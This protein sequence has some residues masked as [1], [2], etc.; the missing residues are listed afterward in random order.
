MSRN[1]DINDTL[2]TQAVLYY[3]WL[4]HVL[5]IKL[6]DQYAKSEDYGSPINFDA[7]PI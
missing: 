5:I 6:G 2:S 7:Y 3:L 4:M 1:F